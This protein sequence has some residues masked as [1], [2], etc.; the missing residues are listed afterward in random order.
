[1]ND[2][3][4][5]ASWTPFHLLGV[6]LCLLCAACGGGGG[7]D[8]D[9][10][11]ELTILSNPDLDGLAINRLGL[12]LGSEVAKPTAGDLPHPNGQQ[13]Y[14]AFFSFDLAE[15]PAGA[16][17]V[18]AEFTVRQTNIQGD[19]FGLM[20]ALIAD[21]IEMGAVF[22]SQA[23]AQFTLETILDP[24]GT[25]TVLSDTAGLGPRSMDVT[26]QVQ[27]DLDAGRARSQFRVRGAVDDPD[28]DDVSDLVVFSDGADDASTA[29]S[30][31][32][33]YRLP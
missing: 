30:L 21:H 10:P 6:F 18:S 19:P 20:Q 12:I 28:N 14:R 13:T 16:S 26:T 4:C 2:M 23:Y 25:P 32:V 7:D 27:N 17:I 8:P 31:R 1:M 24:G 15:I 3:Q 22:T 5:R 9:P 29:P 11:L 33:L